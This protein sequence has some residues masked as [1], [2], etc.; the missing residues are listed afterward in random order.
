MSG[1]AARFLMAL[2][3]AYRFFFSPWLGNSCRFEPTCSAYA[4]QA[5]ARYGAAVGTALTIGRIARCHPWCHAGH[6][7]VPEQPP[8]FLSSLVAPQRR[9]SPACADVSDSASS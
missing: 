2:V 9:A 1:L 7:P 5:L 8:R 6:D 3:R 4:L